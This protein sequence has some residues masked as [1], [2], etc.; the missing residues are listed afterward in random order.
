MATIEFYEDHGLFFGNGMGSPTA[1]TGIKI[2]VLRNCKLRSARRNTACT[3]NTCYLL[4]S[5]HAT[6]LSSVSF[7]GHVASFPDIPSLVAG[8][9][10]YIAVKNANDGVYVGRADSSSLN[11]PVAMKT[12][13]Y[14][15]GL[16]SG[17]DQPYGTNILSLN[18]FVPRLSSTMFEEK[19]P[20]PAQAAQEKITLNSVIKT[21]A[22]QIYSLGKI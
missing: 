11:L 21:I 4:A 2:L 3:A 20:A 5:D 22:N 12:V 7:S 17:A 18:T 8:T 6:V 10:Y 13:S 15:N 16:E 19:K 9:N 1:Y 14:V